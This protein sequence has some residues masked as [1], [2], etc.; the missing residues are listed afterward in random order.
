MTEGLGSGKGDCLDLRRMTTDGEK[1]CL[2]AICTQGEMRGNKGLDALEW[3][4]HTGSNIHKPP[5]IF[6]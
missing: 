6:D 3:S 4:I 5:I 1:H 2:L